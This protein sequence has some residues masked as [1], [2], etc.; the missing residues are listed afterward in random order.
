M[1]AELELGLDFFNLRVGDEVSYHYFNSLQAYFEELKSISEN[2]QNINCYVFSNNFT[3][4]PKTLPLDKDA[5]DILVKVCGQIIDPVYKSANELSGQDIIF[6]VHSKVA[7]I[8][9]IQQTKF[10]HILSPLINLGISQ[11]KSV[12]YLQNK[13]LYL[14]L[15]QDK[16]VVFQNKFTVESQSDFLY[17]LGASLQELKIKQSTEIDLI[18]RSEIL[19][20]EEILSY[21]PKLN[22]RTEKSILEC[23]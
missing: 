2:Y 9:S 4:L 7:E 21:F 8:L 13:V 23:E 22:L 11:D 1:K 15:V 3:C 6:D 12:A 16:K 10:Q 19:N 18:A 5:K 17:F 14:C 20:K